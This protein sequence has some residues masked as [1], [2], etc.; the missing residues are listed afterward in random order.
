MALPAGE[1]RPQRDPMP[2]EHRRGQDGQDPENRE[3]S[4]AA[5]RE[6]VACQPDLVTKRDRESRHAAGE[7]RSLLDA[8]AMHCHAQPGAHTGDGGQG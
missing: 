8:I 4:P 2:I 5:Q 6:Q 1:A 7:Y 3:H